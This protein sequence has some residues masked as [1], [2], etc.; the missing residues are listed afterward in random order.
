MT[1]PQPKP[2]LEEQDAISQLSQAWQTLRAKGWTE[3]Q[4][5]YLNRQL[6]AMA[7][8]QKR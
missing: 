7:K 3:K 6:E 5:I 4:I 8:F 2:D 1:Q